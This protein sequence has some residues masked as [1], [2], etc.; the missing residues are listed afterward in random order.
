ME[1]FEIFGEAAATVEPSKSPFD[2]PAFAQNG[3]AFGL[4]RPLDDLNVNVW[5]CFREGFP[6]FLPLIACIGVEF[7]KERPTAKQF[8]HQ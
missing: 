3:E 4:V 6:K 1:I 5:K 7:P 8:L 2:N